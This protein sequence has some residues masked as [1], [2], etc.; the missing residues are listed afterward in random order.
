MALPL[1]FEIANL[2]ILDRNCERIS[3]HGSEASPLLPAFPVH[4]AERL[5]ALQLCGRVG[6]GPK[7]R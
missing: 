6:R 3:R 4:L 5:H 2:I 7:N 1:L